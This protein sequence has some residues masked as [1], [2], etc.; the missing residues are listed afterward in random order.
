LEIQDQEQGHGDQGKDDDE[1]MIGDV[2]FLLV[3]LG[4]FGRFSWGSSGGGGGGRRSSRRR[5]FHGK[6]I[7]G[8]LTP[9][10][11]VARHATLSA[12]GGHD[13]VTVGGG[14]IEMK[15]KPRGRNLS[16]IPK[17]TPITKEIF[18]WLI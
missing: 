8:E 10:S 1:K 9:L 11:F 4:F 12:C 15:M 2:L 6:G 16:K 7:G 5:S 18:N 17:S 14:S 3:G 13:C